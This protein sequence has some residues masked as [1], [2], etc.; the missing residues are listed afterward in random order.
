MITYKKLRDGSWGVIGPVSEVKTGAVLVTK[1]DGSTKV[2]YVKAVS[3]DFDG[4]RIGF[5][6]TQA[7]VN[8]GGTHRSASVNISAWRKREWEAD[9]PDLVATQKV[10]ANVKAWRKREAVRKL[11]IPTGVQA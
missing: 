10:S 3:K 4:L 6:V 7:E 2:E 9:N 1:K 11:V 5:L 8:F